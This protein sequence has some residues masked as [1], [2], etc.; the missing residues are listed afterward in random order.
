MILVILYRINIKN[1]GKKFF[2]ATIL[3]ILG[4]TDSKKLAIIDKREEFYTNFRRRKMNKESKGIL[5]TPD[6]TKKILRRLK[7]HVRGGKLDKLGVG[8]TKLAR[9]VG[10]PGV[11]MHRD[12]ALSEGGHCH[13]IPKDKMPRVR[14]IVKAAENAGAMDIELAKQKALA[15]SHQR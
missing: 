7:E 15:E 2:F 3:C 13:D 1:I 6:R 4:L 10:V 9:K 8:L 11:V 14:E 12:I 5:D